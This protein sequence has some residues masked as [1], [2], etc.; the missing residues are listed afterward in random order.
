VTT[1]NSAANTT[2]RSMS[3]AGDF[4]TAALDMPTFEDVIDAI[5]TNSLTGSEV[6]AAGAFACVLAA[7]SLLGESTH[8]YFS[9]LLQAVLSVERSLPGDAG[10]TGA[11]KRI[12]AAA[13]RAD[14]LAN[15]PER[16]VQAIETEAE[17]IS[18][19]LAR[20]RNNSTGIGLV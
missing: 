11:V 18:H 4:S 15:G 16:V 1:T 20:A 12:L 14:G 5:R 8:D 19:G 17:R 9:R 3:W 13:D 6:P 10:L 2:P 7:R